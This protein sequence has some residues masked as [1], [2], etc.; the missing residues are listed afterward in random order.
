M[1]TYPNDQYLES[2]QSSLSSQTTEGTPQGD[3]F[4][5]INLC[6]QPDNPLIGN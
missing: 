2:Q 1:S 6:K 5:E 4:V 3:F